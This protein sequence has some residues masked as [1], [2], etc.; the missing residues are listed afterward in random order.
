MDVRTTK[1]NQQNRENLIRRTF[2]GRLCRSTHSME[3][4]VGVACS[5]TIRFG[6]ALSVKCNIQCFDVAVLAGVIAI[7]NT[8]D[9]ISSTFQFVVSVIIRANTVAFAVRQDYLDILRI[10][11]LTRFVK[12]DRDAT[13]FTR[14]A[15]C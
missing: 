5:R 9:T 14:G 4:Q 11:H 10:G 7:K 8:D 2:G 15:N 3:S 13:L 1:P 12:L 6:Y